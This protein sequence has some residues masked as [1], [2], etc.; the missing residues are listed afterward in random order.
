MTY[1]MGSL[2]GMISGINWGVAWPILGLNHKNPNQTFGWGQH[3]RMIDLITGNMCDCMQMA[4]FVWSKIAEHILRNNTRNYFYDKNGSVGLSILFL[5]KKVSNVISENGVDEW[6]LS[7]LQYGKSAVTNA[8]QYLKEHGQSLHAKSYSP[9]S[10]LYFT[11]IDV[12]NKLALQ[13]AS[14]YQ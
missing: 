4:Y 8:D 14:Y 11:D 2:T 3:R 10:I 13:E 12:S 6:S 9:L 7:L 5:G 1:I